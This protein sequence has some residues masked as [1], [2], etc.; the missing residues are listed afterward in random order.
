[1]QDLPKEFQEKND[2]IVAMV[3][4]IV[5]SLKVKVQQHK[6]LTIMEALMAAHLKEMLNLTDRVEKVSH[7]QQLP[8]LDSRIRKIAEEGHMADRL[9]DAMVRM[10]VMKVADGQ[11]FTD[12]ENDI[13][14]FMDKITVFGKQLMERHKETYARNG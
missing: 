6:S 9:L 5:A 4:K 14:T 10:R 13:N 11:T 7:F 1:V 3:N 12:I 2:S 8:L